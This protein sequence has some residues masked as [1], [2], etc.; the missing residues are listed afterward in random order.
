MAPPTD[1]FAMSKVISRHN[2]V[3]ALF[4]G[5]GRDNV[6]AWTEVKADMSVIASEDYTTGGHGTELRFNTTLETSTTKKERMRITDSGQV[7]MVEVPADLSAAPKLAFGDGDTGLYESADDVLRVANA[8]VDC[9]TINSTRL[10]GS[11]IGAGAILNEAATATNPSVIPSGADIDTGIGTS[12]TNELSLITGGAEAIHIDSSQNVSVG[13]QNSYGILTV[14]GVIALDEQASPPSGTSG[15]GK[16]FTDATNGH[17]HQVNESGVEGTLIGSN[18]QTHKHDSGNNTLSGV[19]RYYFPNYNGSYLV[20]TTSNT[21]NDQLY[22][23][24]FVAGEIVREID[25]IAARLY[26]TSTSVFVMGVYD[27][28]SDTDLRPY[29]LVFQSSEWSSS[30]AVLVT[31]GVSVRLEPGKVYWS[32]FHGDT[33]TTPL[34]MPHYYGHNCAGIVGQDM[35][36]TSSYTSGFYLA[37]TYNSTLPDPFPGGTLT[38]ATSYFPTC[39]F[40]YAGY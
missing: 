11:T 6:G 20:S 4:G 16:I 5:G 19:D 12:G 35:S 30:S 17:I 29:N 26:S 24:P 33:T 8:G 23:T 31:T 40:R 13:T 10:G 3:L 1:F 14:E 25:Q 27:T 36:S 15:Y 7:L 38:N 37:R 32:C 21:S 2:Q 9:W 22:V 18:V 28:V 39:L 34:R